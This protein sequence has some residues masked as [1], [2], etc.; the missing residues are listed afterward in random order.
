MKIFCGDFPALL[1][2]FEVN[3]VFSTTLFRILSSFFQISTVKIAFR[4]NYPGVSNGQ[5][6]IRGKEMFLP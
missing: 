4:I 6:T 2:L 3:N 1:Y 5:L